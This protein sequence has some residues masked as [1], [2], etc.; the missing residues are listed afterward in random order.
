MLDNFHIQQ[1]VL[2]V[3]SLLF[4]SK[5][6][7]LF[8]GKRFWSETSKLWTTNTYT[9]T[10]KLRDLLQCCTALHNFKHFIDKSQKSKETNTTLLKTLSK[11]FD[12][13]QIASTTKQKN[14]NS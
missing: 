3:S 2:F 12:S 1:I 14:Y 5:V 13:T 11:F 7:G 4:L 10:G 8:N 9:H 6:P